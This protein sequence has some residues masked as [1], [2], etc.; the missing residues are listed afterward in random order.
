MNTVLSLSPAYDRLHTSLLAQRSQ[1][2]S[3]DVIQLV[4]RALLAGERVSA[5]FYDLSQ[6]KLL[7]QRKSLPLLTPKADKEITKFLDELKA[8]TPKTLG[9]KA[10]FSALQKQVS[11]LMEKFNWKHASP[12]LVQ[13]ALFNRTYQQWQQALEALFSEGN[14]T[15]VFD[16]LQRILNDSARKIPVLGDT[17]SLFKQLTKL[18]AECRDKSALNALEENVMAGYIAA[19]DIATRG[20]IIFGSTAEAVL[21]G[22]P[23]PDA[24]RQEQL[25]KEHYQ[26]VVERMHPWFT[27][28]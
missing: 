23:L 28:L 21:R 3:A 2:Q 14:G 19:A 5:A 7:Q 11:R 20:I 27:A 17:V 16:D 10:Q 12:I 6:L 9:D 1:V 8:I 24:E 18:A 4:N 13:N 26:Q 22:G 15:E 25:I